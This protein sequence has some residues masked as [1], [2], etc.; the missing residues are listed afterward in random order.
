[1]VSEGVPSVQKPNETEADF[2]PLVEEQSLWDSLRDGFRARFKPT[3]LSPELQ[4]LLN[5]PI[6]DDGQPPPVSFGTVEINNPK[7]AL[8]TRAA[9]VAVH[10]AVIG[11]LIFIALHTPKIVKVV[12]ANAANITWLSPYIPTGAGTH[13]GGGGGGGM[14]EMKAPSRGKVTVS[15]NPLA[16][17]VVR[18]IIQQPKLPVP[19]AVNVISQVAMPNLPVFGDPTAHIAPPSSGPGNRGGI[20]TGSGA[21]VGSGEGTGLG[22]GTGGNTG[23]GMCCGSGVRPPALIYSPEPEYSEEARKAKYQGTVILWVLIGTD[24]RAHEIRVEKQVGL[25][26]DEK[27]IEA[28]RQW[29]FQPAME[30]NKPVAVTS[31]VEVNFRL[32]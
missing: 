27:A 22:P 30:G 24:G 5:R 15:K 23:G 6:V 20:G 25:G 1:M 21:G 19:P 2:K 28:V 17:P 10:V 26:L 12:Q 8:K 11:L 3:P 31:E 9:S 16:P 32:Y 13:P 29:R 4:E 14:H 18:P 7:Q